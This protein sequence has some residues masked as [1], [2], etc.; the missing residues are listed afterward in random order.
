MRNLA[1]GCR[2]TDVWPKFKARPGLAIRPARRLW[3]GLRISEFE[4]R[5]LGAIR[6]EINQDFAAQNAPAVTAPNRIYPATNGLDP[7]GKN[8]PVADRMEV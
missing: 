3:R 2:K 7:V 4:Q 5:Q 6:E 1:A 8:A